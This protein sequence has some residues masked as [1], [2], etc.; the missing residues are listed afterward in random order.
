M[1]PEE[2]DEFFRE[3][4]ILQSIQHMALKLKEI[5]PKLKW[6]KCNREDSITLHQ[7]QV[8]T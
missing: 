8:G 7:T 2:K 6:L 4:G 1:S 5:L 3:D